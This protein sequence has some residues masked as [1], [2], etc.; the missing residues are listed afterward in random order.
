MKLK[1]IFAAVLAAAMLLSFAGCANKDTKGDSSEPAG[2][3]TTEERTTETQTNED[4]SLVKPKNAVSVSDDVK[5]KTYSGTSLI[6]IGNRVMEPYGNAYKNMKAYADA[7]NRLKA[8]MPNTKAYCL[9]APTAIEFYAPSKYNTGVS[10]SQYEGMCYIY[11]QLKDIT[12]VNAYAEMAAH[13]D[14]YL[15]FRSDHHWTTLGAY[16][17]YR[18]FAKVAG[19][20]PVDKNTLQTGKLSPFLGLFY[21]DT[22]STALSNDPDYVEYFI[23]PVNTTAIA[24]DTDAAMSNSYS[25]KVINTE[26]TSS[27]KYLAFV[28]GDHGVV[29][30]T[31]DAQSDKSIV[32][33]KESYAA[34]VNAQ[35]G[36]TSLSTTFQ[37]M[38]AALLALALASSINVIIAVP[39][40][41]FL[42]TLI[43]NVLTLFGVPSG[44]F[45]DFILGVIVILFAI[46]AQRKVKGVVK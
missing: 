4:G 12:P 23:P 44:T 14:E 46:L 30:I 37:P 40:S 32:V 15:Y 11:E 25:I 3:Q 5:I 8:E 16:Y 2:E 39:I 28:G 38:A 24:S 18:T 1:R 31:T 7:L 20:T 43:F 10:K 42:I 13:T 27:N 33:I 21:K 9:M 36:L 41:T 35:S 29:K 22:K 26:T 19:F 45:Q 17:A 6:E 34:F